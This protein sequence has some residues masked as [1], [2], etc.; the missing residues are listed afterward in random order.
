MSTVE[1]ASEALADLQAAQK[2]RTFFKAAG[3]SLQFYEA[4]CL[5]RGLRS[6]V[7]RELT[8]FFEPGKPDRPPS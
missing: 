7:R 8:K 6:I 1:V 4:Y 2:S 5:L 3:I